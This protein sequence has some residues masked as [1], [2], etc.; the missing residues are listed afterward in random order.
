MVCLRVR[1]HPRYLSQT[2]IFHTSFATQRSGVTYA[3]FLN[4][5]WSPG[6]RG[7]FSKC[8]SVTWPRDTPEPRGQ[9]QGVE[10][11]AASGPEEQGGGGA[12]VDLW[13]QSLEQGNRPAGESAPCRTNIQG[14][15]PASSCEVKAVFRGDVSAPKKKKNVSA[16]CLATKNQP[17]EITCKK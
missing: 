14:D 5:K 13:I 9:E 12:R 3:S 2:V 7:F 6:P 8:W 10:R 11:R 16:R 15:E 17:S 1:L 4:F